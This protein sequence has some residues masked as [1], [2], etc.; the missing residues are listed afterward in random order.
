MVGHAW[1]LTAATAALVHIVAISVV[2]V[3][4][5]LAVLAVAEITSAEELISQGNPSLDLPPT[6]TVMLVTVSG[7]GYSK[8]QLHLDCHCDNFEVLLPMQVQIA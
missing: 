8:Q 3:I 1:R 4:T 6:S 2:G 7:Y 5:A